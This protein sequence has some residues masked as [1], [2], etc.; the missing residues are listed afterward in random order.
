MWRKM[1]LARVELVRGSGPVHLNPDRLS[2]FDLF[3]FDRVSDETIGEDLFSLPRV[4]TAMA[5]LYRIRSSLIRYS[6]KWEQIEIRSSAP[7]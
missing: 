4:E 1:S 7:L 6:V 2:R 5:N 3:P